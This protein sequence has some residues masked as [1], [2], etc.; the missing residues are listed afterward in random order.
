MLTIYILHPIK[1]V[2]KVISSK[3]AKTVKIKGLNY[4]TAVIKITVNGVKFNIKVKVG[5]R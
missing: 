4:G 1:K 5:G 3:T 2:A